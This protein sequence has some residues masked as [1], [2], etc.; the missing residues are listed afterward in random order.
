M[1]PVILVLNGPNLRALGRREPSTYGKATLLHLEKEW[2]AWGDEHGVEVRTYAS[3]YEGELLDA[4]HEAEESGDVGAV[5][6]N[7]GALTHTSRALR[8]AIASLSIPVIEV[9]LSNIAKRESWR[10]VSV[11]SEVCVGSISGFGRHG[12]LLALA[13]AF[14]LLRAKS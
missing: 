4:L 5:V 9:H 3:S 11:V 13:A 14:E 7:P 12:Y 10:R 2:L 8:D 6:F 1:S